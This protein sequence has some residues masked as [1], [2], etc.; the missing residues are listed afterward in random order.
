MEPTLSQKEYWAE[1]RRRARMEKQIEEIADTTEELSHGLA[2]QGHATMEL[3][4]R[5]R[6][7][8]ERLRRLASRKEDVSDE[9]APETDPYRTVSH[10]E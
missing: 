10:H 9:P 5:L 6:Q 1:Q 3:R 4:E 2:E 7:I 8:E